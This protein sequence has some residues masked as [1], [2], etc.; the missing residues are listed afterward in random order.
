[1]LGFLLGVTWKGGGLLCWGFL[2][3]VILLAQMQVYGGALPE[4][5]CG[6]NRW[7]NPVTRRGCF[8]W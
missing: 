4:P 1:M 6:G 3:G 7:S 8:K 2:L 5:V